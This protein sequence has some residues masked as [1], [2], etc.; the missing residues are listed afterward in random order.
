ME[1]LSTLIMSKIF[2]YFSDCDYNF[3]VYKFYIGVRKERNCFVFHSPC[4]PSS[5]TPPVCCV[6]SCFGFGDSTEVKTYFR[7][8]KKQ[9]K[10]SLTLRVKMATTGDLRSLLGP[11]NFNQIPSHV[12]GVLQELWTKTSDNLRLKEEKVSSGIMCFFN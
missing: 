12:A 11:A 9:K 8:S 1:S 4:P 10:R 6:S 5:C 3:H 7:S 2:S